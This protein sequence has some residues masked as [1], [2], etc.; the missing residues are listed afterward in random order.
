MHTP[1]H[2]PELYTE[3]YTYVVCESS[4][5]IDPTTLQN[6]TKPYKPYNPTDPPP[7]DTPLTAVSIHRGP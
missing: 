7:T 1:S 3:L 5:S 4:A 2:P 6:S